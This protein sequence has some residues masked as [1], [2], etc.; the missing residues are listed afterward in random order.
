M[1]FLFPLIFF[2]FFILSPLTVAAVVNTAPPQLSAEASGS[3]ICQSGSGLCNPLKAQSVT[4]FLNDILTF[5][6][7]IGTIF[8]VL[9]LVFVGFKFTAARGNPGELEKVRTMFLWT[10]VGALV[11]LGAQAIS[12]GISST[13]QSISK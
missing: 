6:I 9:M 4:A 2:S 10:I 3:S 13:I 7:K 12:M 5:V 1:K 8:I 11:I